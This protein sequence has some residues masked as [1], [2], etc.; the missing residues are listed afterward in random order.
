MESPR[1]VDT[2]TDEREPP[3]RA[4][5]LLTWILLVVL[6]LVSF[7]A[8]AWL[9]LSR[10]RALDEVALARRQVAELRGTL[11]DA[12]ARIAELEAGLEDQ[13]AEATIRSEGVARCREALEQLSAAWGDVGRAIQAAGELDSSEAR[14]LASQA[15]QHARQAERAAARCG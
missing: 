5:S 7:A 13:R 12:D 3:P 1:G 9:F 8:A 10:D 6:A 4:P 15:N 14:S 11:A 2:L